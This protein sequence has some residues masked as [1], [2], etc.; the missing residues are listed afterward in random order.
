MLIASGIMSFDR[1][2][3]N[4]LFSTVPGPSPGEHLMAWGDW[5][6]VCWNHLEALSCI[7][8]AT[9]AGWTPVTSAESIW[10]T[11]GL[12][13]WRGLTRNGSN[14]VMKFL[15]RW[16]KPPVWVLQHEIQKI[17]HLLWHNLG[18]SH[19]I[20]NAAI[21]YKQVTKSSPYSCRWD[22]EPHLSPGGVSKICR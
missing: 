3:E 14:K 8:L 18:R 20:S 4:G 13:R 2:R 16:L 17:H 22:T 11:S 10:T 1:N 12:S 9:G 19:I 15:T 6:V 5:M 21:G 7:Y